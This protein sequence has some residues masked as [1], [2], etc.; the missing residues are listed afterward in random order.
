M[1]GQSLFRFQTIGLS[2][3]FYSSLCVIWGFSVV[4][5]PFLFANSA[6]A[7]SFQDHVITD[8]VQSDATCPRP[9]EQT[10][11][12]TT[13]EKVY[14]WVHLSDA[15]PFDRVTWRWIDPDNA[16][17]ATT[18]WTVG[19]EG[20]ICAAAWMGISGQPA[21]DKTGGWK[22]EIYLGSTLAATDV[23]TIGVQS[24]PALPIVSFSQP[25]TE[26]LVGGEI[27]DLVIHIESYTDPLV[28][29]F[30][31]YYNDMDITATFF[32]WLE[33][34][35][36]LLSI[37]GSL[38]DLTFPNISLPAGQHNIS[39]TVGN[40]NGTTTATWSMNMAN[41]KYTPSATQ[42]DLLNTHGNPDYLSILYNSDQQ[43]R[44]E[45]WTYV[46]LGKMYLFWDGVKVGEKDVGIDAALYMNPPMVDPTLFT[47][48]TTLTDVINAFG[49][50]YTVTDASSVDEGLAGLDLKAYYFKDNGLLVSFS[51]SQLVFVETIDI[52][53]NQAQSFHTLVLRET[54]LNDAYLVLSQE[55][56][57]SKIDPIQAVVWAIY[58]GILAW[59][60]N[61]DQQRDNSICLGYCLNDRETCRTALKCYKDLLGNE[62]A[63][64]FANLGMHI[65]AGSGEFIDTAETD[66]DADPPKNGEGITCPVQC[67]DFGFSD[68]S[69]CQPD[70]TQTRTV[71][72]KIPEGCT[73]EPDPSLLTQ[74]CTYQ[75]P[76]CESFIYSEWSEC[77]SDGYQ[78]RDEVSRS[79]EGCVGDPV[80]TQPCD[81]SV[82]CEFT[83]SAW[84]DCQ[85]DGYQYRDEI[86]RSPEG[87]TGDPVLAQE[88]NY[89]QECVAWDYT[90]WSEC[91]SD[92]YQ[93]RTVIMRY[94]EGCVGDG[95][96]V[97][98]CD[99]H[100]PCTGYDYSDSG[101]QPSSL[102]G[103]GLGA[104]TR[105]YRGIPEGCV[106][107][108]AIPQTEYICCSLDP[109]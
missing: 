23:F 33:A 80:L 36:V 64:L 101:C 15:S 93:Y 3:F 53:G 43:R 76:A 105:T 88:C 98:P 30:A 100:P 97:M 41:P 42:N 62:D 92:G 51:G 81:P 70:G 50:D 45:T 89:V 102:Y 39:V 6:D 58:V 40:P 84:S 34:G 79:P 11:F 83:Y 7:A 10:S 32:A 47:D 63:A 22:A 17:Y 94:P 109:C 9:V 14:S 91:Q 75:P 55:N 48:K 85:P 73:T 5:I 54:E 35:V 38:I 25:E 46:A 65:L 13:D 8:S 1:M 87:C 106:G 44:E 61:K 26:P 72:S 95:D 56:A 29:S 78:Y 27:F 57:D 52:P 108:I 12:E 77:Q 82:S 31:M 107:G 20:A 68:W 28:T 71:V 37:N 18:P 99:Y 24:Q 4:M 90:E 86:S 74:S 67:T 49:S 104:I 60:P 2:S 19:A 66:C 103:P 21:A 59:G 69:E 16:V 96:T